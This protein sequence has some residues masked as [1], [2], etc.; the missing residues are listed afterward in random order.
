MKHIEAII[1]THKLDELKDALAEL[2]V[3]GMTIS[4][5]KGFGRS[6]GKREVYRGSSY[7]V[8]FVPKLKVEIVVADVL[9]PQIVDVIM[10]TARTGQIGDGKVFV[11]E[12]EQSVR[13][14]TGDVG[15]DAL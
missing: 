10:T 12:L 14:R 2:G 1:R 9:A 6:K 3:P 4:E 15:D 7:V 13:I 5:V 8:D 11:S